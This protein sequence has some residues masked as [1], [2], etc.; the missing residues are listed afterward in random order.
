MDK[1]VEMLNC[2]TGIA[3]LVPVELVEMYAKAGHKLVPPAEAK[4]KAP[5]KRKKSEVSANGNIR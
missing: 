3:M 2:S 1:R 5:A 4:G